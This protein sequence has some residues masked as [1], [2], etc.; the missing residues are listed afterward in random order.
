M[1][2]ADGKPLLD[3]HGAQRQQLVQ[4]QSPRLWLATVFN[5]AQI[6]GLPA[7]PERPVLPDWQR[8]DRAERLLAAGSPDI[9]HQPG[10]RAFYNPAA[11]VIVLPERAQFSA[12]D[13]YYATALHE[14]G[15][16]TGHASR[17]G[18]DLAH[19]FGSAG[20]AREEL[21]AEIASLVLGEQLG[22]GHDPG[23][24]AAY[25]GSWIRALEDDPREIF[26]AAADAEKIVEHLRGLELEREQGQERSAAGAL[27]SDV[28][29]VR[30]PV[31]VRETEAAMR[32]EDRRIYLIVPYAE[33]D[34]ARSLGARWDGE[35]RA[36]FAPPGADLTPLKK[37]LPNRPILHDQGRTRSA[38]RVR[39]CP[40]RG[41]VEAGGSARDGRPAAPRAG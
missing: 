30:M 22:I 3:E 34:A 4:Y 26:R 18:R 5:A 1:T 39:R 40:A 15:H 12:A 32:T 38:G 37:W 28:V 20:Y 17:L 6:D 7:E 9:R 8:H 19:P 27:D 25:V 33:K 21:R 31:L 14:K 11:D 16:W 13:G 10:D 23:R 41:R 36:W 35:A 2:G 24:H 29:Q